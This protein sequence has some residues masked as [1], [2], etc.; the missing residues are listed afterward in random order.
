LI[1][2]GAI[3]SDPTVGE[4]GGGTFEGIQLTRF[5]QLVLRRGRLKKE[6]LPFWDGLYWRTDERRITS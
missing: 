1:E 3:N 2:G 4:G 5:L 6:M